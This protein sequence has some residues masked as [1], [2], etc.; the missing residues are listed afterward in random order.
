MEMNYNFNIIAICNFDKQCNVNLF[1]QLYQYK[2]Q[3][4][5]IIKNSQNP[6]E[7][8]LN[9]N[10]INKLFLEENGKK[11]DL[12]YFCDLIKLFN[13]SYYIYYKKDKLKITIDDIM[14][15]KKYFKF[16]DL[17]FDKTYQGKIINAKF[18]NEAIKKEFLNYY[19][20]YANHFINSEESLKTVLGNTDGCFFEEAIIL[21]ILTERINSVNHNSEL[22]DFKRMEVK[23]IF[24]LKF[25]KDL[26]LDQVKNMN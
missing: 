13:F 15:I 24:G 6:N 25:E 23:Y 18:K 16:V 3:N 21:D 22:M 5:Y 7:I 20:N 12:V 11:S 9:K 2:K 17:I 8:K 26:K 10:K 4:F 19:Q 14:F 1:F